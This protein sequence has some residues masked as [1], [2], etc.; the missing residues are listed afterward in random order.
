MCA[1]FF[2][3]FYSLWVLLSS[4]VS[5]N[6]SSNSNEYEFDVAHFCVVFGFPCSVSLCLCVFSFRYIFCVYLMYADCAMG[7]LSPHI[8]CIWYV[9]VCVCASVWCWLAQLNKHIMSMGRFRI[10]IHAKLNM[11]TV[12]NS[13]SRMHTR[14][15]PPTH[16]HTHPTHICIQTDY[17]IYESI[18]TVVAHSFLL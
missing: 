6:A 5:L 16:T 3:T 2:V 1:K 18:F 17:S 4:L 8:N 14:S 7:K 11:W 9:C 10:F 13:N 12:W 15:H